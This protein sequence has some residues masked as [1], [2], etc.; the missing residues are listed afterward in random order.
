MR[1]IEVI[2]LHNWQIPVYLAFLLSSKQ[3]PDASAYSTFLVLLV[4]TCT[5]HGTSVDRLG[6]RHSLLPCPEIN[7]E[8]F[9]PAPVC[10]TVQVLVG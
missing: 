8:L 3:Q 1:S 10:I 5:N 9:R 4:V 7:D 6:G 2:P